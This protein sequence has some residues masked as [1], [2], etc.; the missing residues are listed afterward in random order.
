MANRRVRTL[1][2][3]GLLMVGLIGGAVPASATNI[4]NEGCTLGYWKNHTADW[5]EYTTSTRLDTIF[6]FP[7]SLSTLADD[8]LLEALN[9]G[10]GSGIVGKA[11]I[12]L[13]QAAAAVLNAAHESVGYPLRRDSAPGMIRSTVNAALASG[14][15]STMTDLAE[16]YDD[17]NNLGCPL[18]GENTTSK[19]NK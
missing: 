1:L 6:V 19:K 16:T 13:R 3:T 7:A 10:G 5:E 18:S 8:T 11:Q 12:L 14:S 2:L 17:A 9:Y 15:E 4:G